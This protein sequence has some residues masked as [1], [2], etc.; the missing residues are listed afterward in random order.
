MHCFSAV[1]RAQPRLPIR[2]G[3]VRVS[4]GTM[5]GPGRYIALLCLCACQHRAD[6][7]LPPATPCNTGEVTWSGTVM[8]ILQTRCALPTCHVVGGN[9]TGDL[10][11]YGGVL[12][13]VQNGKLL[14]AVQHLPG[15]IPMPP[16]G[17]MIPAC[18]IAALV[19]WV[20]NGAPEN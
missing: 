8:P 9:G 5:H 16:D 1:G 3:T 12:P 14:K 7:L 18:E 20:N 11:S 13:Q 6:E 17:N 15:A 2:S 19:E 4:D 10:T